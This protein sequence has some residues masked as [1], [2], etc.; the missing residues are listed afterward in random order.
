MRNASAVVLPPIPFGEGNLQV[1][2]EVESVLAEGKA[3]YIVDMDG[4]EKRDYSGRAPQFLKRLVQA[5]AVVLDKIDQLPD[6]LAGGGGVSN[7]E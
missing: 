1:L 2:Q 6:Y 4:V 5:G 3:V 7:A